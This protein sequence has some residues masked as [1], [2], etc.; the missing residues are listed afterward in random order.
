MDKYISGSRNCK[1][2]EI[3]GSRNRKNGAIS[4]SRNRQNGRQILYP[5]LSPGGVSF[6]CLAVLPSPS[7]SFLLV[8]WVSWQV[9]YFSWNCLLSASHW[10]SF[11]ANQISSTCLSSG[12]SFLFSGSL[13]GSSIWGRVSLVTWQR[14]NSD[15]L[16]KRFPSPL[17]F[18][19]TA[20]ETCRAR[21]VFKNFTG[22]R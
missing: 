2:G 3:S 6:L 9:P 20:S 19:L 12:G 17:L 5:Q 13:G 7:P 10:A 16:F 22:L 15:L 1:N 14:L 21:A 8:G 4:G 11:S 18:I